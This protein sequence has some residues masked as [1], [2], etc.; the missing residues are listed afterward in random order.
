MKHS[1]GLETCRVVIHDSSLAASHTN[2]NTN[3]PIQHSHHAHNEINLSIM[4]RKVNDSLLYMKVCVSATPNQLANAFYLRPDYVQQHWITSESPQVEYLPM[5]IIT[6]TAP[7]TNQQIC[8]QEMEMEMELETKRKELENFR[9]KHRNIQYSTP[10]NP[11]ELINA[12]LRSQGQEP[13]R[14]G[15]SELR[16]HPDIMLSHMNTMAEKNGSGLYRSVQ[17]V[18]KIEPCEPQVPVYLEFAMGGE[19]TTTTNGKANA[20]STTS[21]CGICV[22]LASDELQGNNMPGMMENSIG[23]Y[24]TG[25]ILMGNKYHPIAKPFEVGDVVGLLLRL[26]GSEQQQQQQ[27]NQSDVISHVSG[28]DTDELR[29]VGPSQ[30]ATNPSDKSELYD[31]LFFCNGQFVAQSPRPLLL[32]SSRA[33]YPTVSIYKATTKVGF[34]CCSKDLQYAQYVSLS[35]SLGTVKTV[36]NQLIHVKSNEAE[37]REMQT[38]MAV[39]DHEHAQACESTLRN[40]CLSASVMDVNLNLNLN[41]NMNLHPENETETNAKTNIKTKNDS[42]MSYSTSSSSES[43]SISSEGR[44]Q[45]HYKH[46]RDGTKPEMIV[47]QNSKHFGMACQDSGMNRSNVASSLSFKPLKIS[48]INSESD[49]GECD[50]RP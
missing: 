44:N 34:H 38:S 28:S 18:R 47:P 11:S 29:N 21:G 8:G 17:T 13:S 30:D 27:Q 36:C 5:P 49:G 12:L 23:Y 42:V 45:T 26:H 22:G 48:M 50:Q 33:I 41:M 19:M 43:S 2:N 46:K 31:V 24:A 37:E 7:Q 4:H 14:C 6:T 32:K 39:C 16:R 15:F 3:N 20:A 40:L 1:V 25:D 10:V 35:Q 9:T